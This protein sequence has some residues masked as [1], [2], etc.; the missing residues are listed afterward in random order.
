MNLSLLKE[1]V[2]KLKENFKKGLP[3]LVI[4]IQIKEKENINKLI[5]QFP[6]E[7]FKS[8]GGAYN[9][10]NLYFFVLPEYWEKLFEE[11][12][13]IN[14]EI[15][16]CTG[17]GFFEKTVK[18]DLILDMH[19]F[20]EKKKILTGKIKVNIPELKWLSE[21]IF[22]LDEAREVVFTKGDNKE[23]VIGL[24]YYSQEEWPLFKKYSLDCLEETYEE[25]KE[26]YG[27]FKKELEEKGKKVIEIPVKVKEMQRYFEEKGL[28]NISKNRARYV[29][30]KL[31]E[32]GKLDELK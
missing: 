31:I 30:D 5:E 19:M 28:E 4:R 20:Y 27:N 32:L 25:W 16:E 24:A 10:D 13:K 3:F 8:I 6:K 26:G 9:Y 18:R 12:D 17:Q 14:S 2:S 11:L 15:I 7:L 29:S 22:R 23:V 1:V 21:P